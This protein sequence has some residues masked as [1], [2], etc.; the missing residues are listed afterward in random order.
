MKLNIRELYPI[1]FI[2]LVVLISISLLA[3][4]D[5]ITEAKREEQRDLRIT[6]MLSDMFPELSRYELVDEIYLIYD[7][8]DIVGYAYIA[9][10]KGYGGFID[11]LVGLEDENTIKGINIVRHTE[12]PGLGAR[13]SEDGY[14]DQYLDLDI[15][16]S[17]MNFDGGKIDSIT[18]ATISSEAV[19]DA[20]RTTALEK[21]QELFGKGDDQ[22][23]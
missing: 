14:R 8:G 20:V 19:A 16:D 21:V 10:G 22:D 5:H 23:E 11:I 4:T 9:Q 12:S 17:R 1:I 3:F 2:T 6:N 7:D 15:A 13:I 18:G